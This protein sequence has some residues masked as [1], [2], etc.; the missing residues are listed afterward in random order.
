MITYEQDWLD[1]TGSNLPAT[2][3]SHTHTQCVCV[4]VSDVCA[5]MYAC[6][7]VPVTIK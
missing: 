2:Y 5:C 3:V 4:C 7:C 6:I 1:Y